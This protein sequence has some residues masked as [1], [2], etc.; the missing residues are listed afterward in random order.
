MNDV[1][2]RDRKAPKPSTDDDL[3]IEVIGADELK[4]TGKRRSSRSAGTSDAVAVTEAEE[5][6]KETRNPFAR[7]WL[8]LT[9]VV[10]ELKKVVWP[11]RREMIVYSIGVLIFVAVLTAF[12]AGLDLGFGELMIR[13]FGG[14]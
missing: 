4:P 9:Q 11:T 6:T 14:N 3:D 13:I 2:K 7:I 12:I 1:A 10:D 8:F 5:K